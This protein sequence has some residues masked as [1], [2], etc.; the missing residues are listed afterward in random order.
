MNTKFF[1]MFVSAAVGIAIMLKAGVSY[2]LGNWHSP[3]PG[4][5]SFVMGLVI[6]VVSGGC[7]IVN[8]IYRLRRRQLSPPEAAPQ[9]E[10]HLTELVSAIGAIVIYGIILEVIGFVIS[11]A[12][13]LS[14]L[15]CLVGKIRP[16]PGILGAMGTS[17]ICYLGFAKLLSVQLPR[18]ILPF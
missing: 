3:G 4:F 14:F 5:F 18:G 7:C 10:H 13:M 16:L 8:V 17:F 9:G 1:P 15:F 2:G 12:I 6:A 11:T